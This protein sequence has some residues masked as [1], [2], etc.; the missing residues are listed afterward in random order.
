MKKILYLFIVALSVVV[1]TGCAEPSELVMSNDEKRV[2]IGL[3]N[4]PDFSEF[5]ITGKIDSVNSIKD[6]NIEIDSRTSL[7][8]DSF[9]YTTIKDKENEA[10][11][12]ITDEKLY[13]DYNDKKE[14][15]ELNEIIID[16]ETIDYCYYLYENLISMNLNSEEVL[17]HLTI[18]QQGLA[19]QF[20]FNFHKD[21]LGDEIKMFVDDNSYLKLTLNYNGNNLKSITLDANIIFQTDSGI[22]IIDIDLQMDLTLQEMNIPN[23]EDY[24]YTEQLSILDLIKA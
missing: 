23:L 15:I 21:I 4:E 20:V 13:L 11:I 3:M 14:Y 7:E 6:F 19:H 8:G 24:V 1:F 18:Y 12:I 17:N 5:R 22:E 2:I 16:H 9:N 10:K